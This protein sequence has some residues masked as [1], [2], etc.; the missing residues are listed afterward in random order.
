VAVRDLHTGRTVVV[1][2]GQRHL[3]RRVG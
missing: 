2:A 3:A 1:R